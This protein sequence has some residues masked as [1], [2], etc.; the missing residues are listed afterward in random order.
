M[1]RVPYVSA[2]GSLMKIIFFGSIFYGFLCPFLVVFWHMVFSNGF[3]ILVKELFSL[4]N[5][6]QYIRGLDVA[7]SYM[8]IIF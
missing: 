1:S 8:Y 7:G 6:G 3:L 2:V 5:L 4:T